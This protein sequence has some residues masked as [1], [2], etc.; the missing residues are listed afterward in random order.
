M[1]I[2]NK[3]ELRAFLKSRKFTTMN[4]TVRWRSYGV[5]EVSIFN[6]ENEECKATFTKSAAKDMGL[7]LKFCLLPADKK[8]CR[9]SSWL[10]VEEAAWLAL[11]SFWVTIKGV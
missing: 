7:D 10:T 2:E 5:F 9:R 4:P 1:M 8:S 3:K 11:G 6:A